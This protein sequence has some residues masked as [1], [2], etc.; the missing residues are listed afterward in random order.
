MMQTFYTILL[1]QIY[2]VERSAHVETRVRNLIERYRGR[3]PKPVD[4]SLSERDSLLITY[5]DQVQDRGKAPL[6]TLAE[7]C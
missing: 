2:G 5:G 4:A 1:A 6:Q 3:V 7:F